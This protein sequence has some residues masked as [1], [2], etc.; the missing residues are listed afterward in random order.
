MTNI[1]K[2]KKIGILGAV[3]QRLGAQSAIDETYDK[4]INEMTNSMLI[5][6]WC[7]WELGDE[8]WWNKMKGMF[9]RLEAMDKTL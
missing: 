3:R 8:Y 9:D 4:R 6:E 1:E 2:L 7:G 5:A